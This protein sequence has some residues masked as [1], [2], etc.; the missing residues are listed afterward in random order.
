MSLN[1]SFVIR[2]IGWMMVIMLVVLS[3]IKIS[4]PATGINNGDKLLHFSS[5]F[6]LTYWFLHAYPKQSNSVFAG[7]IV[8]GSVL[9]WLQSLTAY[10]YFE[11]LD[12]S[13]NILG[14]SIAVFIFSQLRYRIKHLYVSA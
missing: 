1:K 9:E 5:Y 14:A 6:F 4:S 12:L 10:R 13:M 3:L 8:L 2:S 7:F 11:W